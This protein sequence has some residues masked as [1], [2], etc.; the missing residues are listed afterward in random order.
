LVYFE[1]PDLL[2]PSAR[3]ALEKEI[4]RR[5]STPADEEVR[6]RSIPK[7]LSELEMLLDG[8]L[9]EQGR[10]ALDGLAAFLAS[11]HGSL[12]ALATV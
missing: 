8:D 9:D 3:S 7:A 6:W 4:G 2:K 5:L 10:A 11:R 12:S 1:R